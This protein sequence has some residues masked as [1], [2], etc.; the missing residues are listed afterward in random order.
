MVMTSPVQ[1]GSMYPN[2][3]IK[4]PLFVFVLFPTTGLSHKVLTFSWSFGFVFFFL[5]LQAAY[6]RTAFHSNPR[7]SQPQINSSQGSFEL[8]YQNLHWSNC[9]AVISADSAV[10]KQVLAEEL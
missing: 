5:S 6:Q 10:D 7:I 4:I 3:F 1:Y 2:K 8:S 9:G